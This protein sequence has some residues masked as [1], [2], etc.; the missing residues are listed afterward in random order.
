[1]IKANSSMSPMKY[2]ILCCLS[3]LLL[4]KLAAQTMGARLV[5]AKTQKGIPYATVQYG[6]NLG[7]I[8]NGEGRFSFVLETGSPRPDSIHISSMGYGKKGFALEQLRD[9]LLFLEP[10]AI[11]LQGVYLF[12]RDLEVADIIERMKQRLPENIN[13]SAVK[14]RIFLR[15]S[16][17]TDIDKLDMGFEESTIAELDKELIDSLANSVPK[18]SHHYTES[19]L[20]LYKR[21]TDHKLHIIK[22]AELY[23]KNQVASLEELG[24]RMEDIFKENIKRNS[25]L[26][27]KSGLF[28]QKVQVDSIL[29]SMEEEDADKAGTLV[30]KDSISGL[31]DSQKSSIRELLGELYYREDSKLDL[32]D[33]TKRYEF[34]LA[35]YSE[36]DGEGV[37]VVD[38]AP[39]R[40]SA[41]FKGRLFINIEDFAVMHLDFENTQ[42]LRNFRLLGITFRED[43]YMG[44]VRFTKLSNGRYELKF[45]DLTKGHYLAVDRPLKVV[46]KNKHVK[47]RR[48]QNELSLNLDFR[49]RPTEKWELVVYGQE[50]IDPTILS[51]FKED[52]RAKATYMPSY[53]PNFWEGHNIMEPN[54]ALRGF[55]GVE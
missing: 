50:L 9:S 4:P 24:K 26:K 32:I 53:D 54:R 40:G 8:S 45:L 22:A 33:K 20:D 43:R 37:Y 3:I 10:M 12:D 13:N 31:L 16:N 25:Y 44:S 15:K 34:E 23:N 6:P 36:I 11:E 51:N 17:L 46:E 41:D 19:L 2:S 1:M 18:R 30:K 48:K 47:G 7:V 21:G 49:M 14:Q 5:D 27:I 29:G 52:K 39:K 42:R 38:F 28:S 35:G 55:K